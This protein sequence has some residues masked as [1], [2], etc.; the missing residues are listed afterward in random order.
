VRTLRE[1]GKRSIDLCINI[2]S[3]LFSISNFT[4]L[5]ALLLDA[6]V[7][8][9]TMD[10]IDLETKRTEHRAVEEGISPAMVAQK[11]MEASLGQV[12]L[13]DRCSDSCS[14]AAAA[15]GLQQTP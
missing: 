6:Q 5:H 10:I 1:D 13:S 15:A 8:A 11:A 7:G 3:V 14:L 4:Q 2:T 12:N 9:L